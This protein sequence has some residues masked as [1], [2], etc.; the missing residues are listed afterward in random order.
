MGGGGATGLLT[1]ALIPGDWREAEKNPL[2]MSKL[3][4][5]RDFAAPR[6]PTPGDDFLTRC[7]GESERRSAM[8]QG[9]GEITS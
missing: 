2:K 5:K 3:A 6:H 1:P 4:V 7:G 8:L 9:E